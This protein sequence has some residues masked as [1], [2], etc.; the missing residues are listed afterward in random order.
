MI[1][2]RP[3]TAEEPVVEPVVV[4]PAVEPVVVEPAVVEPAV[5]EPAVVE[6]AV[7]EPAVVEPAV[8]E[9]AVVEPA[10]VE[11][12]VVEP[13]VEPVVEPVVSNPFPGK[14]TYIPRTSNSPNC[15]PHPDPTSH[16]HCHRHSHQYARVHFDTPDPPCTNDSSTDLASCKVQSV[17][18]DCHRC[19]P[20]HQH[21]TKPARQAESPSKDLPHS[22]LKSFRFS[23]VFPFSRFLVFSSSSACSSFS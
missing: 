15:F 8:V 18:R 12:A 7:V 21:T 1:P 4:E 9:P 2:L 20:T 23:L 10:V 11:P 5:V 6:P 17:L 14:D 3:V 16:C 19:A 13:A 22:C